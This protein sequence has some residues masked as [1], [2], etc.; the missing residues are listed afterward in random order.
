MC[1]STCL[2]FDKGVLPFLERPPVVRIYLVHRHLQ[3]HGVK[4]HAAPRKTLHWKAG[5]HAAP[6]FKCHWFHRVCPESEK[7]AELELK[8]RLRRTVFLL[9]GSNLGIML[10]IWYNNDRNAVIIRLDNSPL[11]FKTTGSQ[12]CSWLSQLWIFSFSLLVAFLFC[13]LLVFFLFLFRRTVGKSYLRELH[14]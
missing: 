5:T 13:H 12:S 11:V 6:P 7:V 8:G 4:I 9:L 14:V 10:M 1:F 3:S 2:I